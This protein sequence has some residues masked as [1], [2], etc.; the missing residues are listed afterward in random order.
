MEKHI[1]VLR[2]TAASAEEA[3]ALCGAALQR[4]GIVQD[5]FAQK[6]IERERDYPTG[7]PTDIPVAIP[8]C[9]DDG[10]Q[11]NCICLLRLDAP[12]RFRRMD[13]D[14]ESI[15][16]DLVFNLA[17]KDPDQ[18]LA[19]LQRMMAFF[20]D[21]DAV[22]KCRRLSDADAAAFLSEH[23]SITAEEG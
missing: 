12:V 20:G 7:L 8:H 11:A 18:H 3:I 15:E 10:I 2:G 23:I 17:I 19:V 22:E 21:T 5:T 1:I 16:T 14:Q 9:K 6:C 4:E 13:D